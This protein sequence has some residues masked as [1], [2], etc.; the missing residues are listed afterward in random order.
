[1]LK[2]TGTRSGAAGAAR[3]SRANLKV[4]L[5][6]VEGVPEE[7]GGGV[8]ADG[9]V[10]QLGPV[11][12][13]VDA[14]APEL[15]VERAGEVGQRDVAGAAAE[16]A[17]VAEDVGE[18]RAERAV[19]CFLGDPG[20]S[21]HTEGLQEAVVGLR[22]VGDRVLGRDGPGERVHG[23]L[24][25]VAGVDDEQNPP[26][27]LAGGKFHELT[28]AEGGDPD[29]GRTR[30]GLRAHQEVLL[31]VR[32][33]VPAEVDEEGVVVLEALGDPVQQRPQDVQ[34]AGRVHAALG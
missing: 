5:R 10:A 20:C 19:L 3:R 6:H 13:V 12:V 9:V 22:R 8:P 14:P 30:I 18:R 25:R 33:S 31:A 16:P 34:R 29:L 2:I 28:G 7:P 27:A 1:M 26:D 17:L 21:E 23:A 32:L 15:G 4:Q 24:A 11:R